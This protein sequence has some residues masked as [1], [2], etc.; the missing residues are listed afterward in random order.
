MRQDLPAII[1]NDETNFVGLIPQLA[2]A[3]FQ[4]MDT[5]KWVCLSTRVLAI[6]M[7]TF[8]FKW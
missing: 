3:T 2:L 1:Q 6:V 5:C 8:S 7:P 4:Y